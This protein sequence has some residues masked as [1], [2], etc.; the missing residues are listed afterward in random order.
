MKKVFGIIFLFTL[1]MAVFSMP[2]RVS[3]FTPE[4]AKQLTTATLLNLVGPPGSGNVIL[5]DYKGANILMGTYFL[6]G[7]VG[8]LGAFITYSATT[9]MDTDAYQIG[10]ILIIGGVVGVVVTK[11]IGLF[12]PTVYANNHLRQQTQTIKPVSDSEVQEVNIVFSQDVVDAAWR[13]AQGRCECR[14]FHSKRCWAKLTKNNRGHEGYP[15]AWEAHYIDPNGA[16]TLDNCEILCWDCY[17]KTI[18]LE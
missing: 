10:S 15:G 16:A 6:S 3:R 18:E 7:I 14:S 17:I 9:N 4:E 5:G 12:S 13:R 2:A 11:I 8:G 1:T